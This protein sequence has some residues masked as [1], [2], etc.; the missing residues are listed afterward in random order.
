MT[1]TRDLENQISQLVKMAV[2][3][4]CYLEYFDLGEGCQKMEGEEVCQEQSSRQ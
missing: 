3:T 4:E 2:S 1:G